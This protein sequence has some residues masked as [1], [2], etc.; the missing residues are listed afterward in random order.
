LRKTWTA[1]AAGY[2]FSGI[3]GIIAGLLIITT[4]PESYIIGVFLLIIGLAFIA[5][6][7]RSKQ[8]V[9][10]ESEKPL[11]DVATASDDEDS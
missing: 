2:L 8:E 3:V 10:E 11:M 7:L 1:K 6:G 9:P 5:V 4:I